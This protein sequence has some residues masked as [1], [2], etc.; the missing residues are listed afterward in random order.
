VVIQM[1]TDTNK[2]SVARAALGILA[3]GGVT[4]AAAVLGS[5]ATNRSVHSPWYRK[6]SFQPP[7]RAFGPVWTALY[8]A[9]AASAYRVWRAPPSPARTRALALWSTQLVLNT[10]WSWLFFGARKPAAAL[11]DLTGMWATIAAYA[12][13]ARKVD[14]IAAWLIAPYLA[15]TTFAGVL[16]EEIVRLN[17]SRS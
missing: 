14:P 7:A 3:I 5:V 15:W 9:M 16:N 17:G 10:A 1:K 6:P 11:I 8:V 2:H 13:E 12:N 4:A